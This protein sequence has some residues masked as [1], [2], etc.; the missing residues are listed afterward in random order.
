MKTEYRIIFTS[1]YDTI[2]ERD[3]AAI[4]LKTV[5]PDFAAAGLAKRADITKD[6]Y[7]ISDSQTEKVI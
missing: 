3:K 2:E 6:D 1:T 4:M 7:F 5:I